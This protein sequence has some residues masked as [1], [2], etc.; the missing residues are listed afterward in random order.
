MPWSRSSSPSRRNDVMRPPLSGRIAISHRS[1]ATLTGLMLMA[2]CTSATS[3]VHASPKPSPTVLAA[4]S[5]APDPTPAPDPTHVFVIVLENRSYGQVVGSGYIAQLGQQ[6]AIATNYRG[7]YH[8]SLPNY[9]AM[10]SGSTWG[11]ADDGWHSLPAGGL[12]SQLTTAG[13]GRRRPMEG[14]T[15]GCHQNGNGYA[16][17]H[18]PLAYS[19][20]PPPPA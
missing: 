9:L 1:A 11:V 12:G 6:Y 18:N 3:Q 4:P 17:Q 10:T 7:V 19:S 15:N 13:I 8:P 5:A 14:I 2:G 16:A 20:G